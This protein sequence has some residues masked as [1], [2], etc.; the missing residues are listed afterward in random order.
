[1]KK[2]LVILLSLFCVNSFGQ[3][4]GINTTTP[5][6]DVHV[7]GSTQ[8]TNEIQVGSAGDPGKVDYLL[9]SNGPNLPPSWK[10]AE[11]IVIPAEVCFYKQSQPIT[12]LRFI[13]P[14]H[15]I[16]LNSSIGHIITF[17]DEIYNRENRINP[18]IL[19]GLVNGFEVLKSGVYSLIFYGNLYIDL[20]TSF[21]RISKIV[22]YK[23]NQILTASSLV[24]YPAKGDMYVNIPITAKLVQG[25]IIKVQSYVVTNSSTANDS[26][27]TYSINNSYLDFLFLED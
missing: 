14:N 9:F 23:N 16:A 15:E 21:E 10:V 3:G 13:D 1:M 12:G 6:A 17:N 7:N 8:I 18:I 4:I 25:D 26:S 22:I 11:D 2:V 5:K 20:T 27:Y 24:Q 19:G